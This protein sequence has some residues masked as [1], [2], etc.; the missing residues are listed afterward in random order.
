[1]SNKRPVLL[2][3]GVGGVGKEHIRAA[4]NLGVQDLLLVDSD[5]E[6]IKEYEKALKTKVNTTLGVHHSGYHRVWNEWDTFKEEIR[7]PSNTHIYSSLDEVSELDI[8]HAI[9]A[10][11]TS[12]H[13]EMVLQI[14]GMFGEKLPILLE[15]PMSEI[16]LT[17]RDRFKVQYV[18]YEYAAKETNYFPFGSS[19]AVLMLCNSIVQ[20]NAGDIVFDIMSHLVAIA[21]NNN[22]VVERILRI[23][24]TSCAA[25]TSHGDI[26][27]AMRDQARHGVFFNGVQVEVSYNTLFTEQ[28]ARFLSGE[29]NYSLAVAVENLCSI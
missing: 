4:Y 24:K 9:I 6:V 17:G 13:L 26:L 15:K 29:S 3:V 7:L 19:P 5:V 20:P 2:I 22:R 14:Q 27:V 12:T 11:P 8:T 10:T 16:R 21:L 25:Y 1:M 18:G 23:S 28:L